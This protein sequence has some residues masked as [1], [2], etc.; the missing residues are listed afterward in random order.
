MTDPRYPIGKFVF[1]G[2]LNESQRASFIDDIERAPADLRSAV[3]DL[4]EQQWDTSY[5]EG[6]WTV[7]PGRASCPRQPPECVH[8]LQTGPDGRGADDQA[9]HGKS[10]GRTGRHAFHPA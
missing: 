4:S 3:R 2:P 8:P 6:G 10:M 5:R 9:L 7:R 1:N